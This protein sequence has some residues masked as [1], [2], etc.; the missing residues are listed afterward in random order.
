MQTKKSYLQSK[1]TL[2][3]TNSIKLYNQEY[4]IK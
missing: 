4:N 1:N 2:R 3:D